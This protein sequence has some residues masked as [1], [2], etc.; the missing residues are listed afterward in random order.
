MHS[1]WKMD[2][3]IKR[4]SWKAGHNWRQSLDPEHCPTD[5]SR[6]LSSVREWEAWLL[7]SLWTLGLYLPRPLPASFCL[8]E[9]CFMQKAALSLFGDGSLLLHLPLSDLCVTNYWPPITRLLYMV[10]KVWRRDDEAVT[11]L[12]IRFEVN[13]GLNSLKYW[14]FVI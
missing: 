3:S 10:M 11:S 9:P 5:S 8:I 2:S 13:L 12:A 6:R 1:V 14:T 4:S 7:N